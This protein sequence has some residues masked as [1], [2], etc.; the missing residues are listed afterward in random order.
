MFDRKRRSNI[1]ERAKRA[2]F[3]AALSGDGLHRPQRGQTLGG[4][5]V[6]RVDD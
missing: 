4:F 3:L 2:P 5:A 1:A 6:E